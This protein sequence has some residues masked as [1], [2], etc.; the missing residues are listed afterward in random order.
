MKSKILIICTGNTCRSQM[1]EGFL[2]SLDNELTVYSA[3]T[4]PEVK[5]NPNTVEVMKEIG[6]DISHQYPKS[7]DKFTGTDFDYVITVCDNAKETCP[8]FAGNVK[9]RFHIGFEDP[10]DAS[11]TTDEILAVYRNVR[12]Q[13]REEF[14]KFYESIK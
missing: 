14:T 10:A 6:I 1:V 8:Y 3:G 7:V 11:G 12:E 5:V 4:K 2:K 13:I 9:H